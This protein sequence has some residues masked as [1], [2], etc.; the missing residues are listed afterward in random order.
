VRTKP[1]LISGEILFGGGRFSDYFL[2]EF[3][4]LIRVCQFNLKFR[5][6]ENIVRTTVMIYRPSMPRRNK[7]LRGPVCRFFLR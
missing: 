2:L 5:R 6:F 7:I 4:E 1:K 3:D